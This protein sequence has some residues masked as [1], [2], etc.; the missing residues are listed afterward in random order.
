[1]FVVF[2]ILF[3]VCAV[4]LL[5][6][7]VLDFS[8]GSTLLLL[9]QIGDIVVGFGMG[10]GQDSVVCISG[11]VPTFSLAPDSTC[12]RSCILAQVVWYF[13]HDGTLT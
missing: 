3:R 1:M 5:F 8:C 2:D 7:S 11:Q 4:G 6:V 12:I 13:D 10:I 9:L